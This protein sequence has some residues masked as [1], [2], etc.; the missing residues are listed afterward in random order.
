MEAGSFLTEH[1]ADKKPGETQT[2]VA[3]PEH[4]PG[5][6]ADGGKSPQSK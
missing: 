3:C 6:G 4:V 2:G 5:V 1:T